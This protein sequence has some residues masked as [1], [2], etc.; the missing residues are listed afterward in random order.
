MVL[1]GERR[2]TREMEGGAGKLVEGLEGKE[3]FW[4][5]RD[6]VDKDFG[7]SG[8]RLED[9]CKPQASDSILDMTGRFCDSTRH[10]EGLRPPRRAFRLDE[11]G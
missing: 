2:W 3:N 7:S 6:W 1:E 9:W 11:V 4:H 10:P 5:H 8:S